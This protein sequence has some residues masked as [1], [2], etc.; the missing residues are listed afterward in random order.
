M[1]V[2]R[3]RELLTNLDLLVQNVRVTSKDTNIFLGWQNLTSTDLAG[4]N[5]YYGTV[6]GRYIQRRSV[7]ESSNSLVIRDLEPATQYYLAVRGYNSN[8]QETVFS[9][10]VTV[11]V[12]KPETSSAPLNAIDEGDIPPTENPIE[13][14]NGKNVTE[15]GV[16]STLALLALASAGIG[17]FFAWRR[18]LLLSRLAA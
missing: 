13:T 14:Y 8:N 16:D 7:P 2:D 15:T 9:H 6:S 10:E 3:W 17:T 5:V 11:I 1:A 18:Q 12:G 4:Y